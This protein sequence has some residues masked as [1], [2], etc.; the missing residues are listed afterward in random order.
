MKTVETSLQSVVQDITEFYDESRHHF[1]GVN[2]IDSG[3]EMILQ[4]VF[5][6]YG[7]KE[8]L[9]VFVTKCAY[10]AKIPSLNGVI[11]SAWSSEAELGELFGVDVEGCSGGFMLEPDAPKAPLR[12]SFAGYQA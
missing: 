2:G 3:E 8:P 12:K 1:V 5:A 11:P 4:W 6:V 7:E 9:T 10:N